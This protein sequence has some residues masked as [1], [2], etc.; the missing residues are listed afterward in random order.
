MKNLFKF[1]L[2][3]VLL[4]MLVVSCSKDDNPVDNSDLGRF[5]A[6]FQFKLDGQSKNY[7]Y[8]G[9]AYD[10]EDSYS[11][12][13]G[14]KDTT[15]FIGDITGEILYIELP[16][17]NTG[18]YQVIDGE[19]EIYLRIG[20]DFYSGQSGVITISKFEGVGGKVEGSFSAV[21]K[22]SLTGE[23]INITDGS[24]SVTRFEDDD[25]SDDDNN[26]PVEGENSFILNG[27]E[28]DNEHFEVDESATNA[29]FAYAS[30]D[31]G[32][33]IQ[34]YG[35]TEVDGNTEDITISIIIRHDSPEAGNYQIDLENTTMIIDMGER[36]FMPLYGEITITSYGD[37]GD[38]VEGTF[39]GR[40]KGIAD[41]KEY[42]IS[43]GK[44]SAMRTY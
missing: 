30:G 40:F 11:Y 42:D 1:S 18:T 8:G 33:S 6:T 35:T 20:S 36:T 37:I 7:K 9:A 4:A 29:V 16:G 41:G 24:F 2:L 31:A 32:S 21:L 3:S 5:A 13:A 19:N 38:Y 25:F 28:F 14:A 10:A 23:E 17:K 43:G 39:E 12:I 34:I 22:N 15:S 27:Y 44:F 26:N